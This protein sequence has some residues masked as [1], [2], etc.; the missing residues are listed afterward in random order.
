M[1]FTMP[2][3]NAAKPY[4]GDTWLLVM[5]AA[6]LA[7]GL[8]MM[9]SASIEIASRTYGD[10]LFHFKRQSVFL[11]MGLVCAFAVMQCPMR[12]WYKCSVALLL[13]AYVI[14]ILVLIPGLGREVNGS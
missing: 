4:W 5:A 8:V 1:A 11:V 6:L 7:F 14:L 3:R 2:Y 13:V 12:Y 9:T 10:A